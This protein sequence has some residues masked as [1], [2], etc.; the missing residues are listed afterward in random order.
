MDATEVEH[1]LNI[2]ISSK[3][4]ATMETSVRSDVLE[5]PYAFFE[6]IRARQGDVIR[7]ENATVDGVVLPFLG[8]RDADRPVYVAMGFDTVRDIV[9]NNKAIYQNYGESMDVLMGE[10][11]LAGMNPPLHQKYRALVSKAFELHSLPTLTKTVIEPLVDGMIDRIA[12]GDHTELME[13][14]ACRLPVFLIGHICALET[15]KY[16]DFARAAGALMANPYN[17]NGAVAASAELKELFET[18][19]AKKRANPGNDL[20]SKLILSEVDG[21]RLSQSDI[22]STCRA[23]VPAG[24]ET[25]VRALGTLCTAILSFPEQAA[26]VRHNPKLVPVFLDELL[27]W[28]G[29]AQMLPKRTLEDTEIAGTLVPANSHLWCYIGHANRDPSHW[30]NPD[31]FD[32]GRRKQ[33]HL[34]FSFGAHFCVGN[35][36]A[37]RE[38]EVVLTK[39]LERLPGLRLDPDS[40]QPVVKGVIFRSPDHIHA[41]TGVE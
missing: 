30:E 37:R 40:P 11:Q 41:T 17:W 25:T 16:D 38:M 22:I 8:S 26:Q 23:L 12:T 13:A 1:V 3:A 14:L 34:A 19:I 35:Q 20:I 33:P 10:N 28:N 15:E 31:N 36:F 39:L 18:A 7:V 29:P 24:I 21:E 6:G 32:I 5:N 9:A 4:F 2:P 27:R